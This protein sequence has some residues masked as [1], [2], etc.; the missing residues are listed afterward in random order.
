M[1]KNELKKHIKNLTFPL[2]D[3]KELKIIL[4]A[5]LTKKEYKMFFAWID[6]HNKEQIMQMLNLDHKRYEQISLKLIK[7]LNQE[8]LKQLLINDQALSNPEKPL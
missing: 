7:K 4:K 1:I 5:K 2:K 3:D 8:K 6:N